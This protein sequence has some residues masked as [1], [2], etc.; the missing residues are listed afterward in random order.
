MDKINYKNYA[1]GIFDNNM[2]WFNIKELSKIA[3]KNYTTVRLFIKNNYGISNSSKIRTVDYR[4]DDLIIRT[5]RYYSI[6]ICFK[7][8]EKYNREE[9][10]N[11]MIWSMSMLGDVSKRNSN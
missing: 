9:L 6:D 1:C 10:N 8:I 2:I 5:D 3:C 4:D 7:V 11:F